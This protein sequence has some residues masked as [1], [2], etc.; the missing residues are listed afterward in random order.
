[1]A[2][3]HNEENIIAYIEE[4]LPLLE[5]SD[6]IHRYSW[7]YT[8][9][10]DTPVDESNWFWIDPVNSLLEQHHPR[11]SAVGEAYDHPW[12]LDIYKPNSTNF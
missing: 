6:F 12:H 7:Y 10:Y 5:H 11:K 1:M 3:E 9:Y 8:R 4:L 2:R